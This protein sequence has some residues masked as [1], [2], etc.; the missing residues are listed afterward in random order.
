[1]RKSSGAISSRSLCCREWREMFCFPMGPASLWRSLGVCR[2]LRGVC[3]LLFRPPLAK[4]KHF[5]A[6][7]RLELHQKFSLFQVKVCQ[8]ICRLSRASQTPSPQTLLQDCRIWGEA[9]NCPLPLQGHDSKG[10]ITAP[11]K[12]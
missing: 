1:M 5:M 2:A 3:R 4:K 11:E 8:A 6:C 7:V 9:E 10:H 12:P